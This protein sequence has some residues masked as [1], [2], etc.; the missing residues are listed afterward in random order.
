[1]TGYFISFLVTHLINILL[2]LCLFLKTVKIR[3]RFQTPA[4]TGLCTVGAMLLAS[5]PPQFIYKIIVYILSFLSLLVLSK[6]VS[7][8]D[9]RWCR[10]LVGVK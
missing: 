9:I 5:Y 7:R 6:V 3:F 8:E 10:G 1:M 2:S 4:L